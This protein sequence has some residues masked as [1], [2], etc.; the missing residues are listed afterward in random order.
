[1]KKI[2]SA[3]ILLSILLCTVSCTKN[4][5]IEGSNGSSSSSSDSVTGVSEDGFVISEDFKIIRSEYM[6]DVYI[7]EAMHYLRDAIY[8]T[9]GIRLKLYDDWYRK[10]E[11]IVPSKHEILIGCTNREQSQ[12]AYSDLKHNDYMYNVESENVITICGGNS[13][14]TLEGVK[15]FC[16]DMFGYDGTSSQHK[17]QAIKK[18]A[19]YSYNAE[20]QCE[21]TT[22]NG[23]N[24]EDFVIAIRDINKIMYTAPLV[25]ALAQHSGHNIKVKELSELSSDD[26]NVIFVGASAADGSHIINPE[27]TAYI[28]TSNTTSDSLSVIIDAS[29]A[30]Y[31]SAVSRFISSIS[32]KKENNE[33]KI[34][35][36]EEPITVYAFEE[37]LVKWTL[38]E[39]KIS[40]V[41]D[42]VTYTY[43]LY[44][45]PSGAPYRT[46]VL[47]IDPSKAYLYMG[48]T[49]D[50]Y[51][52]SLSGFTKQNVMQ[53][54]TS[55]KENG[56]IPIAG[57]NADFF[58]ISGDYHPRGLTIKEGK[59]ISNVG[60]R[61]WCGFTYDGKFVCGESSQYKNYKDDLRTAVGASHVLVSNG[62]PGE[63]NIGT[64]FS[65]T[66][67][68]RTL[69]GVTEDGTIILAVIDGRQ[70]TKSNGASL[71]RCTS[72]MMSHGAYNAVNLD[73]GGSSC[74]VVEQ[75]GAYK[76]MNSPSDGGLRKVYNS[77]LVIPK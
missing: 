5:D 62:L 76:T 28:L 19:F 67:H 43:Q 29:D 6:T 64:E 47:K 27:T 46:Y 69:A 18:G 26:K 14:A 25:K 15:K 3:L 53:H 35:I 57:V 74:M 72:F 68:P 40:D 24:T 41:I 20:Y 7:V 50:G 11:G 59:L 52:Y 75:N 4:T 10:S 44:T 63:L 34:T 38:K 12:K 1:M 51:E 32:V 61:P 13:E 49:S 77:L 21:N 2:L 73:G 33:A 9:Y 55:A 60:T 65:D 23:V 8:E 31:A 58:D 45:D 17:N 70:P 36:P 66:Q 48:S 39:E 56:I 16:L 42:G 71:A 22:I 30:R 37:D 54:M